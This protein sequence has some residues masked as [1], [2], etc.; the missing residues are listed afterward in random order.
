MSEDDNLCSSQIMVTNHGDMIHDISYNYFG[1]RM[2]TCSSDQ[3]M[4][5]WDLD[6]ESNTW[7]CSNCFQAHRATIW[8]VDWAHPEFGQVIA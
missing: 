8:R 3:N 5:I 4:K 1:N 6:E 7:K 2:V